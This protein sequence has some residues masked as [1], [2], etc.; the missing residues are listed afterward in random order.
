MG[1]SG[2]GDKSYVSHV[3]RYYPI[4]RSFMGEGSAAIV[5]VAQTQIGNVGGE[6]YWSW[7]GLDYRVEWCARCGTWCADQCGYLDAGALPKM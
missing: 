2:Y 4:G 3:L 5:A 7:W 6:P 1:W